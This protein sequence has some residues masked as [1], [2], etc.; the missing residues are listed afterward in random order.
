MFL[1]LFIA[2]FCMPIN[3]DHNSNRLKSHLLPPVSNDCKF[4][5]FFFTFCDILQ[6]QSHMNNIPLHFLRHHVYH[7]L[8]FL[9]KVHIFVFYLTF[10]RCATE[11]VCAYSKTAKWNLVIKQHHSGH[12]N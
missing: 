5:L 8:M 3:A 1:F 10:F 12:L 7:M 11:C 2:D 6:M 9:H 4:S